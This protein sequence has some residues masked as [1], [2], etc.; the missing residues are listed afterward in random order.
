MC[1]AHDKAANEKVAMKFA[2]KKLGGRGEISAKRE[3]E[4]LRKLDHPNIVRF[5]DSF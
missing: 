5:Y 4:I 3:R 1:L 2:H